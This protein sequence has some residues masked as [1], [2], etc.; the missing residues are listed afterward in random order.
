MDYGRRGWGLFPFTVLFAVVFCSCSSQSP[1]PSLEGKNLLLVTVDTLRHDRL[2]SYGDE[3][4]Q[5]PNLDRLADEGVR[6]ERVYTAVPLTLPAHAVMFTGRYPFESGVRINGTNFLGDDAVTLAERFAEAG[7]DTAAVVSAYVVTSKFGLDQGFAAYDDALGMENLFRF[8]AEIPADRAVERF[9]GWLD[10]RDGEAGGGGGRPFFAWLHLYDPHQP[11][12]PPEPYR[13]RFADDL[14]RGEIAFVDSQ[15]GRVLAE[16]ERR[17][18]AAD[19]A[20]VLT[21]DHGEAFGEHGEWGHGLLA[22]DETLRVPLVVHA[23][24]AVPG[25]RVV[26]ERFSLYDLAPTLAEL[27]GLEGL[28]GELPGRSLVPALRDGGPAGDAADPAAEV[29]F[30]TLAGQ[31]GKNWAPLTGLVAGDAKY[32][33]LPERELYDLAADP[34]ESRNLFPERRREGHGLDERL[35]ELMLAA[36]GERTAERELTAEDRRRLAA[37]GYLSESGRTGEAIDPKRGIV[38]ENELREVRTEAQAGEI[39]R[40][41]ARLA[42]LR[43]AHPDVEMPDMYELA[44]VIADGRGDLAEAERALERGVARFPGL[45]GLRL[46][47]ATWL[48]EKGRLDEA[49]RRARA[50]LA[51][52][53]KYSQATSLLGLIA[54]ERGDPAAALARFRE[55]LEVET[56][57]VPL[58]AKVAETLIRLGRPEEAR[59]AY[60]ELLAAGLLDEQPEHLYKSAMLDATLGH[61][62]RAEA[63]FRRALAL[64]PGGVHYLSFA[65]ILAGQGRTAEAA[66]W[67][68]EALTAEAQPLDPGQRALAE[69][70]LAQWRRAG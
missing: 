35:R 13:E 39:E 53:P 30:E 56:G 60:G 58:R 16:L 11:Y 62:E 8:W 23:P 64:E 70:A 40:A 12:E 19:T 59:A 27:F 22:Y 66:G 28:P 33:H 43:A 68:E 4:A 52:D 63:T 26:A 36:G 48:Y 5:T 46:R 20:I 15:V 10:R 55:A 61:M 67:L 44:H 7:Y 42:A 14:Y 9:L 47:L 65:M 25:G 57:S 6:F 24:G 45:V 32:I 50:L 29:Y 38:L 18:L 37:L 17:G 34:A 69:Q 31:E 54:E 3:K 2:G 49:E 41:A 51:E 1:S 21:S